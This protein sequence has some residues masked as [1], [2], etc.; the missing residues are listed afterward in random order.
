M[1]PEKQRIAIAEISGW[2]ETP[3]GKWHRNGFVM[4]DP[5][6]PPDYLWNLN[7]MRDAVLS[8]SLEDQCEVCEYLRRDILRFQAPTITASAEQLAE[9]FLRTVGR[10][11]E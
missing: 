7:A 1:T 5:L 10:W 11:E 2:S 6:N 8:L 3:S 9:A 4:P